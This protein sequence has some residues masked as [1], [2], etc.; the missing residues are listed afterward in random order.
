M[1]NEAYFGFTDIIEEHLFIIKLV[2]PE[3][4]EH[5]RKLLAGEKLEAQ[6][7]MGTIVKEKTSYNSDWSYHL[8]PKSIE[9]FSHAIEVCD[10]SIQ[11]VEENL[12][13][14]G[15]STLPDCYWCPWVSR[16]VKEVFIEDSNT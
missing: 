8:E 15:G 13:S 11:F 14:I 6:G 10:A 12:D 1:D 7:I 4:I 3:K 5:A 16:L 9:F 2:E